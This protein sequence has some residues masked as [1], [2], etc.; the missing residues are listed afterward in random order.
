MVSG[1]CQRVRKPAT[2]VK[3]PSRFAAP[4]PG[5][6]VLER[7]TS[8]LP[9]RDATAFW[10]R[11]VQ[12][13]VALPVAATAFLVIGAAASGTNGSVTA[14]DVLVS[15]LV[16]VGATLLVAEL[17]TAPALLAIAWLIV[18]GFSARPYAQLRTPSASSLRAAILLVGVAIL[19]L[20]IGYGF[21]GWY[22]RTSVRWTT[23]DVVTVERRLPGVSRTRSLVGLLLAAAVLP[24]VTLLLVSVRPHL[25]FADDLL[26]YLVAVV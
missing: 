11:P 4:V 9:P 26:V 16:V 21:R 6:G 1:R 14:L 13:A 17:V 8:E 15:C 20:T 24:L 18:D 10:H 19:A 22:F 25:S 2:A 23:L 12:A 3:K 7:M 5:G